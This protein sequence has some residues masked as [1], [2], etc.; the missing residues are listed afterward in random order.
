V[1]RNIPTNQQVNKS[2]NQQS[3]SSRVARIGSVAAAI[4]L[5][6]AIASAPAAR[7][8]AAVDAS[9]PPMATSGNAHRCRT[10]RRTSRPWTGSGLRLLAV[11]KI[12][13]EGEVVDA[14]CGNGGVDLAEGVRRDADDRTGAEE[15]ACRGG[16]EIVLTEMHAVGANQRG[17]IGAVV[18]DQARTGAV[19]ALLHRTGEVDQRARRRVLGAQLQ[20]PRPPASICSA[21]ATTSRPAAASAM[22]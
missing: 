5:M 10:R 3:F 18:D 2:S 8:V 20:Q 1:P 4:A 6:T 15:R 16:R 21:S 11:V 9:M 7:T 17:D 13:P 14:A 12:G 19:G 22:G